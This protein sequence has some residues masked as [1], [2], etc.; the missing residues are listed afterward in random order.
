MELL[1]LE[2]QLVNVTVN[3]CVIVIDQ[4]EVYVNED[5]TFLRNSD[6]E[7]DVQYLFMYDGVKYFLGKKV[8]D[9]NKC[10]KMS[11]MEI[12]NTLSYE[13]AM[14]VSVA[15]QLARFYETNV[16]CGKC[17]SKM[18][19]AKNERAMVCNCGH[20]AYPKVAPTTITAIIDR[21]HDSILMTRG[22]HMKDPKSYGLVAGFVEAG[23]TF[24][25]CVF[26]EIKEEV[27]LKIKNLRYFAN[28]PW[29]FGDNIMIAY[30]AEL[31]GSNEFVM[32]ESELKEV[33]WQ[34]REDIEPVDRPL[35]IGHKM[36]QAF[37]KGE[38]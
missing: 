20:R 1:D 25:E 16:F 13:I 5:Y 32:Q 10:L 11:V 23:E 35:S 19:V 17:G 33:W 30:T 24:E 6:V 36:V 38:I 7:G 2:Y 34:K 15:M 27:N 14:M 26:R 22:I 29:G 12:R 9:I 8:K 3:D 18:Q 37:R 28:Q 4:N 31:D 21:E